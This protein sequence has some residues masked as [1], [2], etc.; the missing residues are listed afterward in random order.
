M[1]QGSTY[2]QMI[3]DLLDLEEGLNDWEV[4]FVDSIS[5]QTYLLTARQRDKLVRVWNERILNAE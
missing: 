2:Q 5:Q 1:N 4:E 3:D